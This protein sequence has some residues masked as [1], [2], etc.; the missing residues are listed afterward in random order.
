[1]PSFHNQTHCYASLN[2]LQIYKHAF[3]AV[4]SIMIRNMELS[5]I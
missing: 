2:M 3:E 4:V 1:M 5:G